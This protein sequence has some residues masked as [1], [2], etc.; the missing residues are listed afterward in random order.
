MSKTEFTPGPWMWGGADPDGMRYH[1][2]VWAG[3]KFIAATDGMTG[4]SG[5]VS[6]AE[7]EANAQLIAA[8]P[9]LFDVLSQL[10][11]VIDNT[12]EMGPLLQRAGKVLA[13][14]RGD[15]YD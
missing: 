13:K 4:P 2:S 1:T 3:R 14:A 7:H 10:F 6:G 11:D 5:D 12:G 8:A 9:E 15:C